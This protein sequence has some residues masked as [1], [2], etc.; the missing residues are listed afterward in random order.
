MVVSINPT[1]LCRR[2]L[3]VALGGWRE[4]IELGSIADYLGEDIWVDRICQVRGSQFSTHSLR[5][6]GG[7]KVP[8]TGEQVT[9]SCNMWA[10]GQGSNLTL[11]STGDVSLSKEN[12]FWMLQPHSLDHDD[13]D[14]VPTVTI[15]ASVGGLQLCIDNKMNIII[16]PPELFPQ[17]NYQFTTFVNE[18]SS[19]KSEGQKFLI[20]PKLCKGYALRGSLSGGLSF[21]RFR[22][23]RTLTKWVEGLSGAVDDFMC[24]N[25]CEW[26]ISPKPRS[27]QNSSQIKIIEQATRHHQ[28]GLDNNHHLFSFKNYESGKLLSQA[29]A[30]IK[31]VK[32]CVA[33]PLELFSA[34]YIQGSWNLTCADPLKSSLTL[35]IMRAKK[36]GKSD[37]MYVLRNNSLQYLNCSCGTLSY[38]DYPTEEALWTINPYFHESLSQLSRKL[39]QHVGLFPSKG[40]SKSLLAIARSGSLS[41]MEL[42]KNASAAAQAA[43]LNDEEIIKVLKHRVKKFK[44]VPS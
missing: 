3:E 19:S 13:S 20:I 41:R 26:T 36:K 11:S 8:T 31:V 32:R 23:G 44:N 39:R 24:P 10:E 21:Y 22:S 4:N 18:H 2:R 30:Q 1:S 25:T 27:Y 14:P 33:T 12:T 43:A 17:I 35:V 29:E 5:G 16:A 28:L 42:R 38:S 7:A 34:K 40:N 9:I 6:Q 15:H 37:S